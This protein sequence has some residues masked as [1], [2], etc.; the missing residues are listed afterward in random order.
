VIYRNAFVTRHDLRADNV[1]EVVAAGRAR[2]KTE[3]EN[4]NVLKTKGYH[5]EHNFGH[6]QEHLSTVLLT[7][8]LLTFLFHTV[9]HLLDRQYQ[10]IRRLRGTRQGFFNDVQALTKYLLFDTW[11]HLMEFML[12][13]LEPHHAPNTS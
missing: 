11:Q 3:N 9:L 5:L 1:S 8:N 2:W 13:G 6:G 10:Q 7:L 4:H 12:D